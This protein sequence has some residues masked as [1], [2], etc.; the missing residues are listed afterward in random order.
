MT[1]PRFRLAVALAGTAAAAI[2]VAG[3]LG[4]AGAGTAAAPKHVIGVRIVGGSG[5]L[6]DRR[7]G[8]AFVP[9]GANY[10]RLTLAGHSTF[11]VGRYAGS[12]P[13]RR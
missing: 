6:F 12:A 8:R 5:E 1:R 4:A 13:R 2:T 10:V 3:A 7:T 11:N 9:R